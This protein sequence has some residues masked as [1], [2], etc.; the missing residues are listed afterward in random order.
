MH[1]ILLLAVAALITATSAF[2]QTKTDKAQ[3]NW[4]ADMDMKEDGTFMDV[5][6]DVD[7]SIY[8]LIGRHNKPFIQRM[9]GL[10][11]AYQKPVDLELDEKDLVVKRVM[12][13][14]TEIL[15]FATRYDKKA[16]EN[17]L[18]FSS[19]DQD[20]FKP[21]KRFEKIA[22]IHA[23]KF[24]NAGGFFLTV[25]P[26]LTKVLVEVYR[27]FEKGQAEEFQLTV[28]DEGMGRLWSQDYTLGYDDD[29]FSAQAM[30]VD[31]DGIILMLGKKYGEKEEQREQRKAGKATYEYH[32]LVFKEAS[33]TPQDHPIAVADKFL[34]DMTI[35]MGQDGDII[36]AGLYGNKGSFSVRGAFYL[37]LDR[38]SKSIAHESYMD[39]SDDL[40]TSY[41][42]EKEEKKGKKRQI[43][44][45][46]NWSC[47]S[48]CFTI[49]SGGPTA[50]R[51]WWWSST[52]YVSSLTPVPR[53]T[54]AL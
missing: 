6:G 12:L 31:N 24:R 25:S 40:I 36:C 39:F 3:V 18:Y 32:L 10:K 22:T 48:L 5:I 7:N 23:E 38:A 28:Y 44:R 47:R 54:A 19:Y 30:R 14:K 4:G 51:Y 46:R 13:T 42:T 52:L 21:L 11:V 29:K 16:E 33:A 20:D 50:A 37:R 8:M 1:K 34:Q 17:T 49:S 41:M 9:D 26:D 27:P 43:G 45:M 15:V 53:R 35:S 2:A